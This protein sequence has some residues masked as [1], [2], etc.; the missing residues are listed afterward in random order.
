MPSVSDWKVPASVQPKA[1]D[2]GYDLDAALSAVVAVFTLTAGPLTI[3]R[4]AR[5]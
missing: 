3:G 4:F 5:T 2:Y 1:E